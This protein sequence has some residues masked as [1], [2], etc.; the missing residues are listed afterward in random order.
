MNN[1]N[2]YIKNYEFYSHQFT[3]YLK[4]LFGDWILVL[5]E[6]WWLIGLFAGWFFVLAILIKERNTK[7]V[8]M[9]IFVITIIAQPFLFFFL[10][11]IVQELWHKRYSL[12][13]K[14]LYGYAGGF[15][16]SGTLAFFVYRYA[17]SWVD[18]LKDKFTK[19]TSLQ[20]DSNTDIRNLSHI[21]PNSRKPYNVEK[22]FKREQ[23]FVGLDENKKPLYL[24][25]AKWF[26]SHIQVMGTTGSGKGVVVA[27]W[28]VQASKTFGEFV[29][30]VDPKTDE[31]APHVMGAITI[32]RNIKYC[33]IDL[34]GDIGQWNPF[35]NKSIIQIEELVIAAFGMSEKDDSS[36]FYLLDDRRAAKL[37]AKFI[38][39]KG[40]SKYTLQELLS[41]F[42]IEYSELREIAKKF[43][44]NIE[45]LID[46]P[47]V[48]VKK[49]LN[50]DEAIERGDIIYVRGSMRYE[51]V[52]RLQKMYV[53]AVIQSCESRDREHARHVCL[54]LDEFK[55]L[56]SKPA[57]EALGAIRDKRAHVILA[58]QS[59]DDLRDCPKDIDPNS[60]VSS[61]NENCALKLTYQI[62]DPDTA[63]W[64]A[65]MSGK[66]QV[67]DEVRHIETSTALTETKRAERTLRQKERCLI[68]TNML[69][70]LPSLCAALYGDGLAKFVFTSPYK[71]NKDPRWTTP[72]VFDE[73]N[74]DNNNNK[75]S[76]SIS[77]DL[78]DVD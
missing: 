49:G 27:Y 19:K 23:M 13:I 10:P 35:L 53:L 25:A 38:Y 2:Y 71:V 67:D 39:M 29:S 9:L 70:S 16:I 28:L 12:P 61:V 17:S 31:W 7:L 15:A 22:Y 33:Y 36:D 32:N 21:I 20:R 48:N 46:L 78:L 4:S 73:P 66:I 56:I 65:R 68:D 6:Y 54:F 72:T 62:N 60:V 47:V 11:D 55:Y 30:M 69:Q 74:D 59:L 50:L 37:F 3:N 75:P 14:H 5:Q 8:F 24:S 34:S 76:G 40:V 63:D 44:K 58:H 1:L 41:Q 18:S 51:P 77:E 57:L 42:Y 52:K 26:S 64:L 45:E 43:C